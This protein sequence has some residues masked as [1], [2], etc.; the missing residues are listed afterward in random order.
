MYISPYMGTSAIGVL[1]YMGTSAIGVLPYMGTSAIGVL[2][3]MGTSAIGVLPYM[4]IG[5]KSLMVAGYNWTVGGEGASS[6]VQQ[7]L[8]NHNQVDASLGWL[9]YLQ[10]Y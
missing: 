10:Q 9:I 4:G 2:P 8:I 3:Y 6:G 7:V 5:V 1:P